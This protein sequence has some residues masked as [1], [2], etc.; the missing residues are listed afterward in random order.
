MSRKAKSKQLS[1]GEWPK[2]TA[3]ELK[4]LRAYD[5]RIEALVLE[6]AALQ[7]LSQQTQ[8]KLTGIPV[9]FKHRLMKEQYALQAL[10]DALA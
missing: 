5:R 6:V 8:Q 7:Q 2:E 4:L 1:Q 3:R 10:I 9:A